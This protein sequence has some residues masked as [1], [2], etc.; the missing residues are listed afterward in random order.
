[1]PRPYVI[2]F[3]TATIDGKIA[4]RTRFSQLSCPEDFKRLHA[5]RK[6]AGAVMIGVN[7]ANIDDPSLR[8][9]YFEGENPVRIVVDGRL[10]IRED[11]RLVRDLIARTIILTSEKADPAKIE[12]LR[13]RGVEVY[14]IES[15]NPPRIDM[16]KALEKLY[17]LGIRKVLVEGGGDLIWSLVSRDLVDEFRVTYTGYVFGGRDSVSI[18]GGEGFATTAESP[19][20]HIERVLICSCGREV[21]IIFRRK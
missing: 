4:S 10:S 5:A 6:E 9:K 16:E 14:V 11:L 3:T 19:E 20:F 21:H 15:Q 7:T 13:S 12:R 18:V 17:E 8:L 1:M 2:V